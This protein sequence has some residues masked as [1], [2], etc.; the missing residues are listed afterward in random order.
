M[1][2]YDAIVV[3]LGAHGGAT[4]YQFAK[5]GDKVLGLDRFRV[6][7]E[8][9]STHGE[10]RIIREAYHENPAYVPLVQRAYELWEELERDHGQRL[11]VQTGGLMIS[12]PRVGT[13]AGA[14]ASADLYGLK[15]EILN[16]ADLRRRFPA[17]HPAANEKALLEPRA[18]ALLLP[19]TLEAQLAAAKK[20]GAELRFDE[21]A[22]SWSANE[23]GVVVRTARGEYQADRLVIAAGA[24][25]PELV[26]DLKLPLKVERQVMFWF[27]PK[28]NAANFRPDRFPVFIWESENG[29]SIYGFP[30]LGS[31]FKMGIHHEG[32]FVDPNTVD[33]TPTQEDERR[34][35]EDLARCFP[36]A[37]GRPIAAKVCLYTDTP[38]TVFILDRHPRH[39]NVV[40]A[41]CCSGHGFKFASA[42]GEAAVDLVS[43][44]RPKTDL[45]FFGFQ[46]LRTR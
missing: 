10:S 29:H 28:K 11:F 19:V 17:F 15:H 27:K 38:D 24:W 6:P 33:R 30:D 44:R 5:R 34:I 41:S 40:I 12:A 4:A 35:R 8:N 14:K 22:T 32:A 26:A 36:D 46:R 23:S 25:I 20:H 37:D 9:G 42:V 1:K 18:G 13:F 31:G 43:G 16:A 3:G 45:S 39:Q 2:R 21:P 7:H